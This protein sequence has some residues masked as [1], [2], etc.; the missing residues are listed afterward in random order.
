[1]TRENGEL[2]LEREEL[3]AELTLVQ[4]KVRIGWR[5]Q[6]FLVPKE[7]RISCHP[8][9]SMPVLPPEVGMGAAGVGSVVVVAKTG[10]VD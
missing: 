6:G 8:R 3:G 9:V 2:Q 4:A 10:L 7:G 1:M 5:G